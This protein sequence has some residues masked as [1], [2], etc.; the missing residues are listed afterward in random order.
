MRASWASTANP[1]LIGAPAIPAS[2]PLACLHADRPSQK[3][4][5]R[6]DFS[7]IPNGT[8][9]VE[10]RMAV[11]W[12]FGVNTGRL[13]PS[14]FVRVTSTNAAQIFNIYPR[15]GFIGV[16]ADADIAVWDPEA[17]RKISVKTHHQKVDY[18]IFE[19]MTVK[20]VPNFTLS[21]GRICWA[22]GK[23]D[24][25]EGSGR[26]VD[27]PPFPISYEAVAKMNQAK[28]PRAVVRSAA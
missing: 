1:G 26:Y 11:L 22:N 12:N 16:G 15:K 18:N 7:K 14:E 3:A 28:A 23:L 8:G 13:T 20:G 24:V 9:G 4:A 27:R 6:N 2:R 10:D 5:G 17:T 25:A 21:Q 19:G